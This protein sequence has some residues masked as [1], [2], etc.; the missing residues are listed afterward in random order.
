MEGI[1][2]FILDASVLSVNKDDGVVVVKSIDGLSMYPVMVRTHD[3]RATLA[4][5]LKPGDIVRITGKIGDNGK[6]GDELLFLMADHFQILIK[7]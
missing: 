1:N 3:A 2:T 5:R 4:Y 7:G 6:R